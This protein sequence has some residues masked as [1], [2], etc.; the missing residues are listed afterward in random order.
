M[1]F[2]K[3]TNEQ[4]KVIL[5]QD[6]G[7]AP[8]LIQ[9]AFEEAVKRDLY[10]KYFIWTLNRKYKAI[11]YAKH[12]LKM[13]LNEIK[14][15]LY[16]EGF[17]ALKYYK[18]GKYHFFGFWNRFIHTALHQQKTNLRTRKKDKQKLCR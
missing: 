6:V 15:M 11:N 2:E 12:L 17:N 4:L 7:I 8:H 5:E 14:N 10:A 13:D 18:P 1:N 9:G 3:A 16:Y